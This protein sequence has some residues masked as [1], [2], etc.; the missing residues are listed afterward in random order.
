MKRK[1]RP[2]ARDP[3]A[4]RA[5]LIAA[6]EKIFNEDGFFDTDTNK[7]ARAAGFAPQTFYRHFTDKTEIFLAV[8]DS[9]WTAEVEA[10][11][12]VPADRPSSAIEAARIALAFHRRWR[13]FRRSL[14]HLTVVDPRVRS[15]RAKARQAQIVRAMALSRARRSEAEWIAVL[16]KA[17]R[18]CDAAA[19][20]EL[21]DLGM[22]KADIEAV[23]AE[24]VAPLVGA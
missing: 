21:G 15:A 1:T 19:D 8:Y 17:E 7:I 2:V 3:E 4:T 14:R 13:V 23:V 24:A 20:G 9:W 6:A 16:L 22:T 12:N 11:R 18:L 5:A 10:L